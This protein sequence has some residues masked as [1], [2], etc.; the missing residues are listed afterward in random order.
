MNLTSTW[1]RLTCSS[2]H[3]KQQMLSILLPSIFFPESRDNKIIR[4]KI[5]IPSI[6]IIIWILVLKNKNIHSWIFW[7]IKWLHNNIPQL[8]ILQVGLL[9]MDYYT[10][11]VLVSIKDN[12]LVNYKYRWNAFVKWQICA[13]MSTKVGGMLQLKL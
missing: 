3:F 9:H 13:K 7:L 1:S 10:T 4:H 2:I 11:N 6:E 8:H 5:I 12:L